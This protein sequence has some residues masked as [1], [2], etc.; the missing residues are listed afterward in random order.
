MGPLKIIINKTVNLN[1]NMCQNWPDVW[2]N[3]AINGLFLLAEE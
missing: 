3:W 1:Q 2:L